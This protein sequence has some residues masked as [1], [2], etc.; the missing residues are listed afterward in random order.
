M[1][2]TGV[3]DFS[4]KSYDWTKRRP[5]KYD[6]ILGINYANNTTLSIGWRY[7]ETKFAKE[8]IQE[9]SD[10]LFLIIDH[11][12]PTTRIQDLY[13]NLSLAGV[14]DPKTK[15]LNTDLNNLSL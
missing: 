15:L 4:T 14:N 11:F 2:L 5:A 7:N 1:I 6:L 10:L 9:M 13:Y 8:R 3:N 12:N